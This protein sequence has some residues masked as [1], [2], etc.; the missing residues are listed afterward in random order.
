MIAVDLPTGCALSP[1]PHWLVAQARMDYATGGQSYWVLRT[2]QSGNESVWR[3]PG[4]GFGAGFTG[5]TRVT[6][7]DPI[8]HEPDL[9]FLLAGRD[10]P[11][12]FTDG[13]ESGGTSAWSNTVP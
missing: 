7:A 3:N 9:I 2:T 10:A 6:I 4:D 13:F 12:I 1:G 8:D 11:P 5:W